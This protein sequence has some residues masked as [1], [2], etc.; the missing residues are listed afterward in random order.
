MRPRWTVLAVCAVATLAVSLT[1]IGQTRRAA[2]SRAETGLVGVKLYDQGTKLI[3]MFGNPLEIQGVGV[4]GSSIGPTGGGGSN[5]EGGSRGGARSGGGGGGG[6]ATSSS[7]GPTMD[8]NRPFEGGFSFGNEV[9]NWQGRGGTAPED[10]LSVNPN[11]GGS[12]GGP[13]SG[14][15]GGGAAAPGGGGGAAGGSGE[16][17][18]FTRWV[19]KRGNSKYGFILD[20]SNRVIQIE[21]LGLK[22]SRVRTARGVSFGATF[23]DLIRKYGAPEGYEIGGDTLVVR[24]LINSK[25]A[26]RL[27]RLGKDQP[28]RVTGIVVSGGKV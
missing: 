23:G 14:G 20:K 1:A 24:F 13:R 18:L 25:V 9:L 8:S 12:R 19:Y 5:P 15:G 17:V 28:H 11:A 2:P 3:G 6:G 4:G 10:E 27:N 22:D 26:F 16:R 7:R 21:A